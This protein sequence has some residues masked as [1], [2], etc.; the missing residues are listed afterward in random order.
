VVQLQVLVD[1]VQNLVPIVADAVR[2]HETPQCRLVIRE[3]VDEGIR[4]KRRSDLQ[5]SQ[6]RI[7]CAGTGKQ[8]QEHEVHGRVSNLELA[9]RICRHTLACVNFQLQTFQVR[10][11]FEQPYSLVFGFPVFDQ[12]ILVHLSSS[13]THQGKVF[14]PFEDVD[15]D[16]TSR[17]P[18][19]PGIV[20]I[21]VVVRMAA[22]RTV[23]SYE[24]EE[25]VARH[26]DSKTFHRLNA[27]DP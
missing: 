6:V 9:L 13:T 2:H 21:F 14:Q 15:D 20:V 27:F 1:E 10:R 4:M 19:S 11:R 8:R 23:V 24:I 18:C 26:L 5:L 7:S 22:K 17:P 3:E 16:L 12:F 25:R